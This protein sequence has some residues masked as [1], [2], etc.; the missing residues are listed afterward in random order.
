MR[1]EERLEIPVEALREALTN[2]LCHRLLDS[3]S[4]SVGIS[5]FDDR[6]E[7]ENTGHLPNELTVET[8]KQSHRSFPQNPIIAE[9]LFKTGFLESWGTGVQRMMDA[10][11]DAGL[12]E[13]EYGTDGLFVWIT[14]KRPRLDTNLDTISDT[15]SDTISDTISDTL[16]L[17]AKQNE[18]LLARDPCHCLP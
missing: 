17:S 2:A 14:F 18:V 4:G 11:K 5:V 6:V 12:P 3:P 13:P 15:S 16:I 1:R 8:I 9:A 10:C 7:I